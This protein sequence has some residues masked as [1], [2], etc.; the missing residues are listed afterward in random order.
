MGGEWKNILFWR[1][2]VGK[3]CF[4]STNCKN[5]ALAAQDMQSSLLISTS[6][7]GT[8]GAGSVN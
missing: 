3:C 2:G 6:Q 4:P 7:E 5:K 1:M 8:E